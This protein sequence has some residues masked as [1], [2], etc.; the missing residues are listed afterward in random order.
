MEAT[1]PTPTQIASS[2]CSPL[3]RGLRTTSLRWASVVESSGT[4]G[5][6]G[7]NKRVAPPTI[8]SRCGGIRTAPGCLRLALPERSSPMMVPHGGRRLQAP[9]HRYV[10]FGEVHPIQ[11]L[12]SALAAPYF[13][14][15][16]SDGRLNRRDS[17]WTLQM[18][19]GH[20]HRT[21]SYRAD[22]ATLL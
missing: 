1:G 18:S 22:R 12:L 8:S 4:L 5:L 17:R 7:S 3:Q 16:A 20:P 10:V 2:I 21:F 9:L 13:A 15:T 6:S 19:G 11:F 14:T